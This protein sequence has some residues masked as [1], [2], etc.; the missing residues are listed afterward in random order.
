[1][2]NGGARKWIATVPRSDS[3]GLAAVY[4]EGTGNIPLVLARHHD[5]EPQVPGVSSR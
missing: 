4:I 2:H 3:H 1:M 5:E